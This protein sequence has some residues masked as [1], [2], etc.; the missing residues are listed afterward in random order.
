MSKYIH[1]IHPTLC[2][3]KDFWG[4]IKRTVNGKAVSEDQI[5]MI[6]NAIK[7]NLLINKNDKLLDLGCGNG[8]LA[9]YMFND[10]NS[11]LGVDF[12]APL[13]KVAND[14]FRKEPNF[15]FSESDICEFVTS[16]LGAN[17][18]T[19]VLIY[20]C[21]SY[22]TKENSHQLLL[23]LVSKYKNLERVFI[24]NLPDKNKAPLFFKDNPYD[25][26]LLSDSESP[27]GIWRT[28]DEFIE[29]CNQT[30]WEI[31]FHCMPDN[32]YSHHYRYDVTLTK[33]NN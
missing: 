28:K 30:G 18:Y 5:Q 13:L 16:D 27:I 21:F 17:K 9:N 2:D 22:L 3:P 7:S 11:Y 25:E 23:N 24:G 29:L 1:K 19:K 20:G 26:K 32:F 4:Q 10:I 14:N 33:K 31:K 8:A 6:I 12:S 15:I